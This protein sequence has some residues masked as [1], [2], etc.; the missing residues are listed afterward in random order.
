[1][2]DF[3]GCTI[4]VPTLSQIDTAELLLGE[5]FDV[6]ERRP[7]NSRETH[8]H[9]SDFTFD[10]LRLYVRQKPSER[11]LTGLEG[12]LFEVQ[13]KTVLQYA[14]GIATHELI[15]KTDEVSWPK[16]RIAF[17][18][19]AMLEHAELAIAEAE[20]LSSAPGVSKQDRRTI[21]VLKIIEQVKLVWRG[22]SL[23]TNLKR[24]AESISGVLAAGD[25]SIDLLH[26]ILDA[27]RRR[28][29]LIPLDLS[30]YSFVIQAVANSRDL[31]FERTFKRRRSILV[32]HDGMDLPEWMRAGHERIIDLTP[33]PAGAVAAADG[34]RVS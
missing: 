32:I 3:F 24:L 5:L 11:R 16:Q 17:Q 21:E 20:Q 25:I 2:E 13:I 26:D 33:A 27:E 29:G 23:P 9:A 28:I 12:I 30:P 31:N 1:M 8:K 22:D 6:V 15:Y 19:K 4:I 7:P 14:W 10:D 18:V 34:G